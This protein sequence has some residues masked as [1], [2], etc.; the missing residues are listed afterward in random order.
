MTTVESLASIVRSKNAGPFRL[1]FD[2]FFPDAESY[3][4]VAEGDVV[5]EDVVSNLYGVPVSDVFGP[6]HKPTL[7][8]IKVTI[9]RPTP[10]GSFEDTDVYGAQQ[11]VPLLRLE[12][13]DE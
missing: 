5:T 3:R 7:N 2:I 1:T 10:A 8:A 6:Y 12:V 13:P 4:R 11:H 9:V